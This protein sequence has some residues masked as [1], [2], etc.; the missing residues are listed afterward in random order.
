MRDFYVTFGSGHPPGLGFYRRVIAQNESHARAAVFQ[1]HG[2]KWC[3]MCRTEE[4]AGVGRYGLEE[5]GG[6]IVAVPVQVPEERF[7]KRTIEEA[8]HPQE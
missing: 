1:V 2:R 8:G 6:P 7:F 3:R 5:F 4:E